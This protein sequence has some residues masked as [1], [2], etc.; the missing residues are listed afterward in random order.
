MPARL[1]AQQ[2]HVG[3]EQQDVMGLPQ[4]GPCTPWLGDLRVCRGMRSLRAQA[5]GM[6]PPEAQSLAEQ[7]VARR[8]R[9]AAAAPVVVED[10]KRAA[11]RRAA[12]LWVANQRLQEGQMG[13]AVELVARLEAALARCRGQ[14]VRRSRQ[15]VDN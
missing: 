4:Q 14:Q 12:E 1:R 5:E 8:A 3:T 9:A 13:K 6:P 7:L 11:V 15:D 2:T 10:P